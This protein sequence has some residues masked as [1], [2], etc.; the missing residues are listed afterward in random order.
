[1]RSHSD[2]FP[3]WVSEEE[4]GEERFRERKECVK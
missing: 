3:L 4:G 1:M 2:V